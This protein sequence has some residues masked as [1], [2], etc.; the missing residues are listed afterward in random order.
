MDP[1][2]NA[3]GAGGRPAAS[4]TLELAGDPAAGREILETGPAP[5]EDAP[6]DDGAPPRS[7]GDSERFHVKIDAFEGPLEL[8]VHLVREH[9]LDIHDIPIAFITEQYLEYVE[10]LRQLN[11]NL[12][13]EY[14]V[15]AAHLVYVKS[16]I[17]L[18]QTAEEAEG[19]EDPEALRRELQHQLIE[20]QKFKKISQAFRHAEEAQ[21]W[22]YGRDGGEAS[23]P[24]EGAEEAPGL[25]ASVFDLLSAMRR[26]VESVGEEGAH[27][28]EVDALE[29]ADMRARLLGALEEAGAR[30][31][32]F[33]KLF[34]TRRVLEV[35]VVFLALLELVKGNLV[36]ARQA[37]N[38]G[39]IH[40]MKAVRDE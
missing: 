8:L 32:L 40:I 28:V 19:E 4:G 37:S 10:L 3:P 11:I 16:R 12:A 21:S 35:V 6:A 34:E 7:G 24:G 13:S 14:L 30:G 39:E 17:L 25:Q 2:E 1:Q 31:V 38:F 20:Y 36:V 33:H 18:P 23:L 5:A 9:R 26:L 22:I 15:M 27:L 29:V